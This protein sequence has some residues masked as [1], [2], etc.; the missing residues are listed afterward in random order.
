MQKLFFLLYFFVTPIFADEPASVQSAKAETDDRSWDRIVV[1]APFN[2]RPDTPH[3]LAVSLRN[4]VV[5]VAVP[6]L[7]SHEQERLSPTVKYRREAR[8]AYVSVDG[9]KPAMR[10]YSVDVPS[11]F[12][13]TRRFSWKTPLEQTSPERF[14]GFKCYNIEGVELGAAKL[15]KLLLDIKPVALYWTYTAPEFPRVPAN[16]KL[17]LRENTVV[18]VVDKRSVVPDATKKAEP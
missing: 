16:L 14:R 6:K 4:G 9:A 13:H 15:E 2:P 10:E 12:A 18:M 11:T 8:K 5:T 17:L 1:P 7:E 3:F